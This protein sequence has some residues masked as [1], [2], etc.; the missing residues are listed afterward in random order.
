MNSIKYFFVSLYYNILF[1]LKLNKIIKIYRDE[2]VKSF[3][4]ADPKNSYWIE[5][6][7]EYCCPPQTV[8]GENEFQRPLKNQ[9]ELIMK[10]WQYFP[11]L[12]QHGLLWL[13]KYIAWLRK[14]KSYEKHYNIHQNKV[15]DHI[16][17]M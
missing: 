9:A 14:N 2:V 4:L 13:T 5:C 12:V 11:A 16:Y 1:N 10:T 17:E 3:E 15:S 8:E 7:E 6:N